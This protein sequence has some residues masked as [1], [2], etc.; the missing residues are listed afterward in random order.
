MN[1]GPKLALAMI[2]LGLLLGSGPGV[3]GQ[4]PCATSDA[5][6]NTACGTGALVNNTGVFNSALGEDALM[7]NTTGA[8]NSAFGVHALSANTTGTTNTASGFEALESNTTGDNNTASGG[9]AL[10]SNTTGEDNT[11]A[12]FQALALNTT[13]NFNTATGGGALLLNTKG[14]S[15]TATGG[16]A[17]NSNT[18]GNNN[19]ADGNTALADNVTGD[20]NTALGHGAG[21]GNVTGKHNTFLGALVRAKT[22]GLTNATALGFG[23][24]LTASDSIVL[25]NNRIT[26]IFA[27][28]TSISAISDRREKKDI[29]ALDP[30]LGLAFV[31][32]LKPVSYRFN[33]GD[34]TERYGFVA[35]DLEQA[36]PKKLR[37]TVEAAKPEHGVALIERQ[38]DAARTYRVAYGELIA[39]IVRAIQEQQTQLREQRRQLRDQQQQI[40]DLRRDNQAMRAAIE[41]IAKKNGATE[42]AQN[43]RTTDQAIKP[44]HGEPHPG[45]LPAAIRGALGPDRYSENRP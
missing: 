5:T 1:R 11:A 29:A 44:P 24:T 30:A 32:G 40:A 9:E 31:T 27:K 20:G 38:N 36:L 26:R 42:L 2:G 16:G 10:G 34:E 3:A 22:D 19:T 23:A 15:N 21:A 17:L 18:T 35:Q 37:D 8:N 41:K 4:P 7:S 25:G 45:P 33:N 13:G 6:A 28:V 43:S 12:G 14:T 39:P